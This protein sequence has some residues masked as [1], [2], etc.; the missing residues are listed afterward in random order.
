MQQQIT[1]GTDDNCDVD[2]EHELTKGFTAKL[3]N[4]KAWQL[5]GRFGITP[6]DYRD[7]QQEMKLRVW[8][9]FTKFNPR[10]AHWRAFVTTVVERHV[11]TILQAASR[12]KRWQGE[13]PA[14]LS[15]LVEDFDE[16]L[17]EL[18][19]MIGVEHREELIGRYWA[20]DEE[21]SDLRLDAEQLLHTLPA[22]LRQL[23]EVLKIDTVSEAARRLDLPRST[24]T[25][26]VARIRQTFAVIKS[27]DA[28]ITCD[29]NACD[30]ND[31][32]PI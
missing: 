12:K 4:R 27:G 9:R 13:P 8:S 14:S 32:S 16:E 22:D 21:L 23:C 19:E 17:V 5:I 1:S 15:E 3:I 26:M 10:R 30:A 28:A 11:A 20:T 24:V 29:V 6:T 18:G 25:S 7:L 31:A 2:I